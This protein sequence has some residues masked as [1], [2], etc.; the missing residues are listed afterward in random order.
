MTVLGPHSHFLPTAARAAVSVVTGLALGAGLLG[1]APP[2][3]ADVWRIHDRVDPP[4]G[5]IGDLRA[6]SVKAGKHV[7]TMR[8]R[9]VDYQPWTYEFFVDTRPEEPGPELVVYTFMDGGVPTTDVIITNGYKYQFEASICRNSDAH[10]SHG[11]KRLRTRIF[12]SCLR[13]YDGSLPPRIRVGVQT[14]EDTSYGD[15]AP[16]GIGSP[17]RRYP[18]WGRWFDVG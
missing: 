11:R 4:L 6:V 10:F 1:S 16:G 7:T 17:E 13:R 5:G 2:A 12:T 3:S 8:T 18:R 9:V 15:L 14:S